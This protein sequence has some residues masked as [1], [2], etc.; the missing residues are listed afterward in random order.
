MVG[1]KFASSRQSCDRVLILGEGLPGL[2]CRDDGGDRLWYGKTSD[3][4]ENAIATPSGESTSCESPVDC[5][6]RY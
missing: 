3:H 5:P 2:H 6:A 1:A 4:T